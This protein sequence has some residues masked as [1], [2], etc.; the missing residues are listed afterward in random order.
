MSR[1]KPIPLF[2]RPY[3]HFIGLVSA[4]SAALLTLVLSLALARA[5]GAQWLSL[6]EADE[7]CKGFVQS[8]YDNYLPGYWVRAHQRESDKPEERAETAISMLEPELE[9]QLK[10]IF[11]AEAKSGTILLD[12]DP[13]INA[14]ERRDE[15]VIGAVSHK[16]DHFLVDVYG[17]SNGR[18]S[19]QPDVVP[20]LVFQVGK[21]TFVNFHYPNRTHPSSDENLLNMLKKLRKS[22]RQ[23]SHS[24]AN[25]QGGSQ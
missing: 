12:F 19:G 13:V 15:Y 5:L 17:V 20:E 21:W 16:G 1:G 4:G 6:H 14:Q 25:P 24:S 10:E 23:S 18:E 2:A 7:S 11:D 8:Y 9:R 3:R 22:I